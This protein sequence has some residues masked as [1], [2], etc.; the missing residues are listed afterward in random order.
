[1]LL[2]PLALLALVAT[3]LTWVVAGSASA[4]T[5]PTSADVVLGTFNLNANDTGQSIF[6]GLLGE[7]LHNNFTFNIKPPCTD[8]QITSLAP[9][10]TDT[11][12]NSVNMDTGPMLHHFVLYQQGGQDVSCPSGIYPGFMG[13]RLFAS[14]NE[15]TS[16]PQIPGYGLYIAPGAS[17]AMTSDL[18]NYASTP[19]TVQIRLHVT[20]VPGNTLKQITPVWLDETGPCGYS[21]MDVGA[22]QTHQST[23]WTSNISGTLIGMGGHVHAYGQHISAVDTTTNTPLCDSVATQMTM[24]MGAAAGVPMITNMTKCIGQAPNYVAQIHQGDTIQMD[25]YYNAPSPQQGVMGIS[26]MYIAQS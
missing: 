19:Q 14:G 15:R 3:S 8:C 17:F 22:G 2:I 26:I 23:S 1:M 12:G 13:K 21:Y 25:S 6:P 16:I 10:L 9:D 18:M 11:S 5:S 20:W 4:D 24:S 7:L